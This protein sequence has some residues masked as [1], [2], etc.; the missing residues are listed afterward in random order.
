MRALYLRAIPVSGLL[1]L[2][3]VPAFVVLA[4]VSLMSKKAQRGFEEIFGGHT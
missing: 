3:A 1:L 4:M 2:L